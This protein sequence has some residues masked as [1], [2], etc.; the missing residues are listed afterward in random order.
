MNKFCNSCSMPL[1]KENH[2]SYCQYCAD[3]KGN[4]KPKAE[5][6]AGIAEFHEN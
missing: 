1:P 5:I 2:S 4:L 3:E 6:Q